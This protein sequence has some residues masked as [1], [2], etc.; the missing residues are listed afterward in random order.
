MIWKDG[1]TYQGS[2]KNGKFHG[3][4]IHRDTLSDGDVVTY[5]GEYKNDLRDGYGKIT[6]GTGGSYYEGYWANGKENGKGTQVL[7]KN[8]ELVCITETTWKDGKENGKYVTQYSHGK[9]YG[10]MVDGKQHGKI[11]T[12]FL[13]GTKDTEYYVHGKK[14]S[15]IGWLLSR[16]K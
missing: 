2:W 10:Q 6:Y 9:K 11:R 14:V 12:V 13:D 4:G 16:N 3:K 5:E 15:L 7:K 1:S 8:G